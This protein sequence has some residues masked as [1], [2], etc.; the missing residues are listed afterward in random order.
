MIENS[1][2]TE[3]SQST[4]E[5]VKEVE[6]LVVGNS[7]TY[8]LRFNLIRGKTCHV[9]TLNNKTME[10]ARVFIDSTSYK[11]LEAH[12][13]YLHILDN[14]MCSSLNA[15]DIFKNLMTIIICVEKSSEP[16]KNSY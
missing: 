4:K 10:G 16:H 5:S 11:P 2:T 13:T 6:I 15:S 3:L 7:M 12:S 14:D 1:D 8:N 9:E